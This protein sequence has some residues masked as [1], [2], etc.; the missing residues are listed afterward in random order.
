MVHNQ[1]EKRGNDGDTP[2]T[3]YT[4]K[5]NKNNNIDDAAVVD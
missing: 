3:D 2:V 4:V 1:E 5:N